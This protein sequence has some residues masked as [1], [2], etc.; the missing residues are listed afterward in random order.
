MTQDLIERFTAVSKALLDDKAATLTPAVYAEQLLD[1][2]CWRERA[3]GK[4]AA[5]QGGVP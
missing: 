2:D 4:M 5:M 3:Y 1:I